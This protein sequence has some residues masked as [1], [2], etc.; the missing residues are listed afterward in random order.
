MINVVAEAL[1][2]PIQK[3]DAPFIA[4]NKNTVTMVRAIKK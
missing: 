4:V 2:D 3:W 1:P